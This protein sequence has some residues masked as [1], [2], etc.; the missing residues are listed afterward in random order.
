MK[1][2]N[3]A[4]I[5]EYYQALLNRD[6]NYIGIFYV[7]VKTTSVFCISTCRARKPKKENVVFY[8][9]YSEAL[10]Q[11]FRPCKICCPTENSHQI[12]KQIKAAIKIVKEN[13]KKR[14]SD[15]QLRD[16]Q[17]SPDLVRRWFKKNYG[18]TFHTFQRMYRINNAYKE[19]RDGKTATEVAF[20]MGYESLSGFGY[21][22]KKILG[23]SP[24]NVNYKETILINRLATPIGPMFVCATK[25]G[26]CLL[27]FTNRKKLEA[28][29]AAL[30]KVLNAKIIVG[31]NKHIIQLRKEIE[32]Y[33]QKKRVTFEVPLHTPGTSFQNEVWNAVK[34][35][36]FGT[37]VTYQSV[38][39][40]INSP[41][42]VRAV[43]NANGHNRIAIVIPCHRII[44]KS[45]NL[46][47]YGGGLKRKQ[48][49]IAFEKAQ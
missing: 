14:I 9:T 5:E 29:F 38:A 22:Y 33:F 21:T 35:I 45:G 16:N 34:N 15:A 7:A 18:I 31:E 2:D 49:L 32:E 3:L 17:I 24:S 4:E 46:G 27:E 42:A 20:E 37:T 36:S 23:N 43:A 44:R 13:A 40:K 25:K 19:L 48:W 12:P 30:Q 6:P 10:T 11:G 41:K 39:Q 47:G 8:K 26:I 1:I 28:E